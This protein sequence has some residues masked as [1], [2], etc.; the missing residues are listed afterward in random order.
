MALLRD[1]IDRLLFPN[2]DVHAIPVLDG[3]FSPNTR[4]DQSRNLGDPVE[5]PDDLAVAPDGALYISSGPTILRCI[6]G[7]FE[8]REIF[9]TAPG[10]VGPL[11]VAGD[12]RVFAGVSGQG[13]VA[14]SDGGRPLTTLASADGVPLNCPTALAFGP[15]EALLVTDGSRAHRPEDWLPDLMSSLPP[16]GRLVATEVGLRD[17]RVIADKLNWPSGVAATRGSGELLVAEAWAHRLSAFAPR[18][19]ASRVIVRNFAG[20]PARLTVDPRTGG[21]WMAFFGMRTQ[22]VEFVLRERE[23]CD[24]MMQRVPRDLWISPSLEGRFDYREPTQIGR[25]KKLGI[26]K[27]W[28]P[29]RSY[30]LVAQLDAHGEPVNSWHSRVDGRVH[31]VT[32]VARVGERVLAVSK[33]RDLLVA[34][35]GTPGALESIAQGD[36]A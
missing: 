34:L 21:A 35:T 28:A 29:P 8:Q 32:A 23:F 15:D 7:D 24:A 19:G 22:L 30:G 31:G 36:G 10:L 14:F 3:A 20:Y 4:L 27:P 26:Q 16:S 1:V 12:G 11:A 5:R 2:R 6:G 18:D 33:G 9:A 25:I 17:S 13:V